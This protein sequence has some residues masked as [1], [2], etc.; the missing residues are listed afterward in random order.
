MTWEQVGEFFRACTFPPIAQLSL[1][2]MFILYR[3][4]HLALLLK[5]SDTRNFLTKLWKHPGKQWVLKGYPRLMLN[6]S[7]QSAQ[8]QLQNLVN[9]IYA[10]HITQKPT[11]PWELPNF[12]P[13]VLWAIF[14]LL[15]ASGRILCNYPRFENTWWE[16]EPLRKGMR[17]ARLSST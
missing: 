7:T 6:R 16:L 9:G 1:N 12:Q 3:Q 11:L 13:Q 17:C 4:P 14:K 8:Q 2:L 10:N 5:R 15:Q